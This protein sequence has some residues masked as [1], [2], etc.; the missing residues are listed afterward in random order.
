MDRTRLSAIVYKKTGIVIDPDDPAFAAI[1]ASRLAM[2]EVVNRFSERLETLPER[3]QA[4]AKVLASE[5]ACQGVQCVTETLQEARQSLS[6]ESEAE[7]RRIAE[8][9]D[10]AIVQ[11]LGAS[12][13]RSGDS[14]P[15]ARSARAQWL[16]ACAVVGLVSFASGVVVGQVTTVTSLQHASRR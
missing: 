13:P 5:V 14:A 4:S 12:P 1:E 9:V 7:Q 6:A 3:I 8:K 16:L 2:E 11:R 15:R 10:R